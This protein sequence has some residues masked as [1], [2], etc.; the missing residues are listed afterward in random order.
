MRQ[1]ILHRVEKDGNYH[2][3]IF[4]PATESVLELMRANSF[5][6]W[7]SSITASAPSSPLLPSP[8]SYEEQQQQRRGG[9]EPASQQD[10]LLRRWWVRHQRRFGSSSRRSSRSDGD[11]YFTPARPCLSAPSTPRSSG[12]SFRNWSPWR[13]LHLHR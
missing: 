6:P 11:L 2:P 10:S 9:I 1:Q 5:V 7:C 3:A 8:L 12:E 4:I 13:K